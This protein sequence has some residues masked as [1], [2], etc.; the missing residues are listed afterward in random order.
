MRR[1]IDLSRIFGPQQKPPVLKHNNTQNQ[2]IHARDTHLKPTSDYELSKISQ[3][4]K[5]LTFI[6][7]KGRF[8][9]NFALQS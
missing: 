3:G 7:G 6:I 9:V 2:G 5:Y 8:S 4:E 1:I